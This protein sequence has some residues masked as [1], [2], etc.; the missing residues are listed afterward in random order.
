MK[1]AT[2]VFQ[3]SVC[4]QGRRAVLLRRMER[5]LH[6]IFAEILSR[7]LKDVDFSPFRPTSLLTKHP[8]GWPIPASARRAGANFVPTKGGEQAFTSDNAGGSR[9]LTAWSCGVFQDR[10]DVQGPV[11]D[12]KIRVG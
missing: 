1:R 3:I 12:E 7:P 6:L 5:R 11:T 9:T 8:E 10:P 2:S 4:N